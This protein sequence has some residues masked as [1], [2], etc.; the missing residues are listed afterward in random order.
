MNNVKLMHVSIE[1]FAIIV[2]NHCWFYPSDVINTIETGILLSPCKKWVWSRAWPI[3]ISYST[4]LL[5]TVLQIPMFIFSSKCCWA[6][7]IAVR[8]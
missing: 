2:Y 8:S 6:F 3:E 7:A 5:L 1:Q 4:A